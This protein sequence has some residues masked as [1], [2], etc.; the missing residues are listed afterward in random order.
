MRW[1]AIFS[2]ALAI[3]L[4]SSVTAYGKII[5]MNLFYNGKNHAYHAQEVHINVDGKELLPK[6]MP[7][8]IVEERTLLPM[9]LIAQELGCQVTWNEETQQIFLVT[10]KDALVFS[11]GEKTGYRNGQEFTMDVPPMIIN[12]RTMMPVRALAD[13]LELSVT[14]DEPTRTVHIA[15]GKTEI[16]EPVSTEQPKPSDSAEKEVEPNT[17][18]AVVEEI[19][20]LSQESGRQVYMIQL[21][22]PVENFRKVSSDNRKVVLEFDDIRYQDTIKNIVADKEIVSHIYT[23]KAEQ[24]GTRVV[25]ELAERHMDEIT[26]SGDGTQVF[27]AFDK[28]R[29]E[30]I[31]AKYAEASNEDVI[32]IRGDGLKGTKITMTESPK[33]ILVQIP[34]GISAWETPIDIDSLH[35]VRYASADTVEGTVL[36]LAFSVDSSAVYEQQITDDEIILTITGSSVNHHETNSPVVGQSGA[37]YDNGQN[38]LYL[39]KDEEFDVRDVVQKDRYLEG[40]FEMILPRDYSRTYRNGSYPVGNRIMKDVQ[41]S[42]IHGRTVLHFNQSRINAYEIRDEGNYYAVYVKN[43]KEVYDKVLILD[44]GHGGKDAGTSGNGLKEKDM[45]LAVVKKTAEKLKGSGVQVYLTRDSDIYPENAARIGIA[46]EIADALVTVH[47]NSGPVSANGTEMLYKDYPGDD[48]FKLTS[49]KLAAIMQKNVVAATGNNDRGLKLR[50][51]LLILNQ[52]KVPAIFAEI[53]FLTNPNDALK[54]SQNAYQ[55]KVAE[56]LA[57]GIKEAMGL[58]I[59]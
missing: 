52:A 20:A 40:Y 10:D 38:I 55:E 53:V 2:V 34:N 39:E 16:K 37:F 47:M 26:Q 35:F 43:P 29:V 44:A 21:S 15:Y 56:G 45:A 1:K 58:I 17:G 9:R 28:A 3:G 54:I 30:D 41:I 7:A 12:D 27:V 14:W 32:R 31:S 50:T 18:E 42:T 33:N 36:Q 22:Q 5:D 59:R 24:G 25:F 19:I 57:N 46:N 49:K 6:D 4:L 13:A 8:V 23:E 48:N 51:D 11:I